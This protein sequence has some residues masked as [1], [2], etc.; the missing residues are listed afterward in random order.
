[1]TYITK[2]DFRKLFKKLENLPYIGHKSKPNN[3]EQ[4]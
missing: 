4:T 2:Q 3:N 1:M